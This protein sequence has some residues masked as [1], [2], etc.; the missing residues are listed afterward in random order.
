MA[1]REQSP[2]SGNS[3]TRVRGLWADAWHG[4]QQIHFFLPSGRFANELV[5]IAVDVLQSL[6]EEIDDGL[7]IRLDAFV[8]SL[9]QA[10]GFHGTHVDQLPSAEEGFLQFFP[11]FAGEFSY[12]RLNGMSEVGEDLSVDAIGLG[13]FAG[14][15]G[16]VAD[17]AGINYDD[18]QFGGG[19]GSDRQP[20]IAAGGLQDDSLDRQAL[21][22]VE[23]RLNPLEIVGVPLSRTFPLRDIEP[24]FG[25]IDS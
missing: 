1:W 22:A 5:E 21:D 18:G 4:F 10:V 8:A 15:F 12:R 25:N 14:G 17:L 7:N 16:E 3:A 11:R 20:F 23:Q 2:S 9:F 19:Q 24:I 6:I 13:E